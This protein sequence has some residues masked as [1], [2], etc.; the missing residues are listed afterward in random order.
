MNTEKEEAPLDYRPLTARKTFWILLMVIQ[1]LLQYIL[2]YWTLKYGSDQ[3]VTGQVGFAGTLVSIALAGL[4]IIYAYFQ[5]NAQKRDADSVGARI[6]QMRELLITLNTSGNDIRVATDSLQKLQEQIG[7]IENAQRDT[8]AS[9]KRL[10]DL[11]RDKDRQVAGKD[12]DMPASGD[13]DK[14]LV[15]IAENATSAAIEDQLVIFNTLIAVAEKGG[16][17]AMM[18]EIVFEVAR[19]DVALTF[20]DQQQIDRNAEWFEGM[21]LGITYSLFDQGMVR[22]ESDPTDESKAP[23]VHVHDLFKKGTRK[24]TETI[25]ANKSRPRPGKDRMQI[26]LETLDIVLKEKLTP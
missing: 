19:R 10:E 16:N 14:L 21:A 3:N 7:R 4:A 12:S 1:A 5:T 23:T 20:N 8:L 22:L 24:K 26:S 6:S 13:G 9:N 11:V 15:R 25:R 17:S 2:H 18:R